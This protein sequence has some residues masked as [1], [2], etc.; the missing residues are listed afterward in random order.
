MCL[1]PLAGSGLRTRTRG[2]RTGTQQEG[3]QGLSRRT[4]GRGV[5]VDNLAP[6]DRV[7]LLDAKKR[8]YLLTLADGGEFH[9][10]AGFVPHAEIIGQAEGVIVNSTKG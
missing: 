1:L 2:G 10:H 7:M 3:P 4:R 6:G 8:R 5:I 9:T